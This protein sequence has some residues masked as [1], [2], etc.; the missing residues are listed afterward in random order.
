[1][2]K[3][4]SKRLH[5]IL[6]EEEVLTDELINELQGLWRTKEYFDQRVEDIGVR[7]GGRLLLVTYK[8]EYFRGGG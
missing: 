5:N 2:E 4:R 6:D 1:M 7:R 3:S 8:I